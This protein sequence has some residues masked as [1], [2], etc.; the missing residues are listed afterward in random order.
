[1][2]SEKN[3]GSTFP[4]FPRKEST[5]LRILIAVFSIAC[6]QAS[7]Q[8]ESEI[9]EM[10][11]ANVE[12]ETNEIVAN[13]EEGSL[14][15]TNWNLRGVEAVPKNWDD[16]TGFRR[17]PPATASKKLETHIATGG[18]AR[19]TGGSEGREPLQLE[20]P[21][22]RYSPPFKMNWL[23]EAMWPL[24]RSYIDRVIEAKTVIAQNE[25][26]EFDY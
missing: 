2:N 13:T 22:K 8:A 7:V 14:L 11:L 21:S 18:F 19:R 10:L 15:N 4:G 1:L 9:E 23:T 16:H 3:I 6:W 17:S 25:R 26:I 5:M 24:T 20:W 12:T